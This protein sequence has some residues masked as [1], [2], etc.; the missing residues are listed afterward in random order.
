MSSALGLFIPVV[1]SIFPIR[2]ALGKNALLAPAKFTLTRQKS[3]RF[4]GYQQVKDKSCAGNHRSCGRF[5][6]FYARP[7]C[8]QCARTLWIR[9]L[10]CF[11]AFI[12]GYELRAVV[13]YR[14]QLV[15]VLITLWFIRYVFLPFNWHAFWNGATIPQYWTNIRENYCGSIFLLGKRSYSSGSIKKSCCSSCPQPQNHNYVCSI[16]R[17]YCIRFQDCIYFLSPCKIFINVT[18]Q[19]QESSMTYQ[20]EQQNGAFIKVHCSVYKFNLMRAF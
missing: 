9:R 19:M 1:A 20:T 17:L 18:Y 16:A 6:L 3:S 5:L 8:G 13:K 10:L 14:V 11:P 7:C 12:I 2:N 4:P 15:F